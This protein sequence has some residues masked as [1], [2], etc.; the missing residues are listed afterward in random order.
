MRSGV[1][2]RS[3][4]HHERVGVALGQ[5]RSSPSSV[6]MLLKSTLVMVN[7]LMSPASTILPQPF[8]FFSSML[9]SHATI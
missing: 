2:E 9:E 1:D 6:F 7:S 4:Y 8:K 3:E 5:H